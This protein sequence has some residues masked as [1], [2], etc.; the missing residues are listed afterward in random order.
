MRG[1]E[2]SCCVVRI[3]DFC[4]LLNNIQKTS[5]NLFGSRILFLVVT[6]CIVLCTYFF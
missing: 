5:V 4:A 6:G 2:G 3:N 1:H